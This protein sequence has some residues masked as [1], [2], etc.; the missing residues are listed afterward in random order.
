MIKESK[1]IGTKVPAPWGWREF[2]VG[3]LFDKIV[4]NSDWIDDVVKISDVKQRPDGYVDGISATTSN[5]QRSMYVKVNNP[6]AI[7]HNKL[8]S[9][10]NA[11]G[12]MFYQPNDF[13]VVQDAYALE[14]KNH[15]YADD[16][17]VLLFLQGAQRLNMQKYNYALKSG[18]SRVQND[19]VI[20]PVAQD[21]QPDYGWMSSYIREL[22]QQRIHELEQQ[23]IRELDTYLQVTGLSDTI[24]SVEEKAVL[25][26]WRQHEKFGGGTLLTK[27]FLVGDLFDNYQLKTPDI[28]GYSGYVADDLVIDKGG[29]TPYLAAVTSNNGISGFSKMPPNNDGDVI[30][31]STTT[32]SGDTL[33]YQSKPFIGRQQMQALKLENH[34]Y[35]GPLLAMFMIS[36]LKPHLQVFDYGNKLTVNKLLNIEL[37]LPVTVDDTLDYDFMQTFMRAQEKLAMQRLDMFRQVQIDTTKA[38]I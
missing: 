5:N 27:R 35:M 33:F 23:R 12:M 7:L 24:L 21:D 4:S 37:E 14:L 28:P 30:T 1:L 34:S 26:K 8:S 32:L 29:T 20:L 3:D 38:V 16:K 9:T 6:D 10:A 2:K 17:N 25:D 19:V 36:L 13:V 15:D 18:W 22:E 11:D 31:L